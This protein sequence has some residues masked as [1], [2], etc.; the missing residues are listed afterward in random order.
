MR[1]IDAKKELPVSHRPVLTIDSFYGYQ[2]ANF[3]MGEW[4]YLIDH[5]KKPQNIVYWTAIEPVA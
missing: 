3:I 4:R 2:V 1:W 5:T